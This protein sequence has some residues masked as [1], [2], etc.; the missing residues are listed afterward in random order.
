MLHFL[1][2]PS[3]AGG[4][5]IRGSHPLPPGVYFFFEETASEFEFF[6]KLRISRVAQVCIQEF[7]SLVG[8]GLAVEKPMGR[9]QRRGRALRAQRGVR[10][11]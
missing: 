9:W 7:D 8:A 2:L 11:G 1:L 10:A 5:L 3:P 4:R 6:E